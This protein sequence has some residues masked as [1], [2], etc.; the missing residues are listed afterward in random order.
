MTKD[1]LTL[2]QYHAMLAETEKK[3]QGRSKYRNVPTAVGGIRFASKAE[4]RH[5]AKLKQELEYSRDKECGLR[6]FLMQVPFRLPGGVIYR[7]DFMEVR[8]YL[9]AINGAGVRVLADII[10]YVDVKGVETPVFKL[11]RKQV[12]ELYGVKI[13]CVKG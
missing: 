5:Y 8:D 13:E 6:Y 2:D 10:R 4:A 9:A 12:E 7:C 3:K 1:V 11:K